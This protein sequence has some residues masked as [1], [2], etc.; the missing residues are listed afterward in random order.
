MIFT[1]HNREAA[2]SLIDRIFAKGKKAEIKQVNEKRTLSQNNLY[3][4]W[5]TCIEKET[6][7]NKEYLHAYFK[8]QYLNKKKVVVFGKDIEVEES[9]KEKDTAEFSN[10]MNKIQ[11]EMADEG[12]ILPLPEDQYYQEFVSYYK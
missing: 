9:T 7:N 8:E 3:W 11:A 4:L 1:K 10:Y 5:L 2:I 12:I 6:G